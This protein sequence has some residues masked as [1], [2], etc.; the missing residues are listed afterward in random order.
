MRRLVDMLTAAKRER[1]IARVQLGRSPPPLSSIG[2][3]G[4]VFLGRPGGTTP[5]QQSERPALKQVTDER[6]TLRFEL[7]AAQAQLSKLRGGGGGDGS[8]GAATASEVR[9]RA[10]KNGMVKRWEKLRESLEEAVARER[11]GREEAEE[12]VKELERHLTEAIIA[13]AS[14]SSPTEG[15]E[16][17]KLDWAEEGASSPYFLRGFFLF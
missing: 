14:K 17:G 3:N 2:T 11:R 5:P 15:A 12:K 4:G 13:A 8:N 10:E 9:W 6:D 7:T 1:D 16:S